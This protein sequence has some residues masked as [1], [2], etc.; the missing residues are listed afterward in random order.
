MNIID[1]DIAQIMFVVAQE[2]HWPSRRFADCDKNL[3]NKFYKKMKQT[4]CTKSV[5]LL[6]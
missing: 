3:K 5:M 4:H 1:L 2:A 6:R